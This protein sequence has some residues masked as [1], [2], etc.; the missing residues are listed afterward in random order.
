MSSSDELQRVKA[1]AFDLDGTVYEGADLVEGALEAIAHTRKRGLRVYYCTNNST[2]TRSAVAAK[3][4]ALGIETSPDAVYS[5]AYGAGRVLKNRG[6]AR[7]AVVGTEGLGDELRLAGLEVV[8]IHAGPEAVV[9]GLHAGLDYEGMTALEPLRQRDVPIVACNRDVWF[10]GDGGRMVPG[11]GLTVSI[12][13]TLLGRPAACL[14]GKPDTLLLE[15]LAADSGFAAQE[16][17]VVGDSPDTDLAVARRF[18]A[19]SVLYDRTGL[20]AGSP[21]VVTHMSDLTSIL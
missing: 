12:I 5:A 11:C 2:R 6:T 7:V 14:I 9:V 4:T 1:V 17:L 8:E 15:L 13:E 18:G 21:G 20:H 3:L 10:P 19:R 16:I